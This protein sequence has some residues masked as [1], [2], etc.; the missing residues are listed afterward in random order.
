MT[1]DELTAVVAEVGGTDAWPVLVGRLR[2]LEDGALFRL[3]LPLATGT[4]IEVMPDARP[5][6][7]QPRDQTLFRGKIG[8]LKS[9]KSVIRLHDG[10][11]PPPRL[12]G[13]HGVAHTQIG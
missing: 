13:A 8:N 9:Q 10:N 3:L 5:D 11:A 1:I 4:E 6:D 12:P 7:G 2:Q